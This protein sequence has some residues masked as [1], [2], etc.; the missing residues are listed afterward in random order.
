MKIKYIYIFCFA[1]VKTGGTELLHQLNFQ[2]NEIIKRNNSKTTCKIVYLNKTRNVNPTPKAFELYNPEC[3]N[4]SNIKDSEDALIIVPETSVKEL[5]HFK[6]AHKIIWW[7]SV[8]NFQKM[9]INK[10]R[11]KYRKNK[12]SVMN[13]I[14]FHPLDSKVVTKIIR[15][16]DYN[17]YQC[18]YCKSFIQNQ[19]GMKN[20]LKL[21]DYINDI[22]MNEIDFDNREDIVVYFPSKGYEITRHIIKLS[23][24]LNWKP[25]QNMTNDEVRNLLKKAKVYVDFGRFPGKDRVP[26]EAAMSGCCIITGM[27]GASAFQEDVNIDTKY[28]FRDPLNQKVEIVQLINDCI[29]NYNEHIEDFKIYR[30]SISKEKKEFINQVNN[31][32]AEMLY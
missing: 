7:L 8:D 22:Y 15:S 13:D 11:W 27:K 32:F 21:S 17:L 14:L 1:N 26:R 9:F 24:E 10:Y 5:L 2:I 25:I 23:N 19:Y 31:I 28:K 4:Y 12:L 18:E 20:T 29:N 16:V 3:E 6:K 30:D